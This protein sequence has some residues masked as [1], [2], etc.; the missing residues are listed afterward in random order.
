M[1]YNSLID[2]WQCY[3]KRPQ[4]TSPRS[5]YTLFPA[6]VVYADVRN[7][8]DGEYVYSVVGAQHL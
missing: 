5:K 2:P 3:I 4:P 6:G 7:P 1:I 8:S